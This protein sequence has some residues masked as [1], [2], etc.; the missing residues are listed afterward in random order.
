MC[1]KRVIGTIVILALALV[2]A[3]DNAAD[4]GLAVDATG[5]V[6]GGAWLDRNGNATLDAQDGIVRD[7]GVELRTPTGGDALYSAVTNAAGEFLL[8]SV[9]VGDYRVAVDSASAGD[10]IQVL[11][12]DSPTL[13]VEAADTTTVVVAMTYPRA[14]T[15]SV[16]VAP[17]DQVFFVEGRI[18]SAWDNFGDA[19]LHIRD[20]TGALAAVRVQPTSSVVGDSVRL[21]GSSSFQ[22]GR[23]VLKDVQLFILETGVQAPEPVATTTGVAATAGGG[24]LDAELVQAAAAVV[25]DTLRN[26]LGEFVLQVDDGSGA[27][28]VVLDRDVPFFLNFP[29]GQIIGSAIDVTGVLVPPASGGVGWVLKP[30]NNADVVVR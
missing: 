21:R 13:T 10:S 7:L 4:D 2:G 8:Q 11:R 14:T 6:R 3:C 16:R 28:D 19:G 9:M 1:S 17:L 22:S 23:T 25:Q 26:P 15:D 30:R 12:V 24:D 27:L 5:A 18:I 20:R 29:G